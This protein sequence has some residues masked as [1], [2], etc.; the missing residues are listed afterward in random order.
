MTLCAEFHYSKKYVESILSKLPA[1]Q[2]HLSTPVR[3]VWSGEGN[4]ILETAAGKRE[5][6]DYIIFTC[7]SDDALRILDAGSGATP[8]E[9]DALSAFR[10]SRNEV[11][12][13]S[14]ESVSFYYSLSLSCS[15]EEM[16]AD[17]LAWQLM[18]RSRLAWSCWNYITRTAVDEQGMKKANDPQLSL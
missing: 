12:L 6:F 5:T 14:D 16:G 2:L 4:A 1:A 3:A 18:P 9:R 8:A 17:G 10:W 15:E 11:W 7:H 13:H